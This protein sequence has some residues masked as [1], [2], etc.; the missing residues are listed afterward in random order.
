MVTYYK[1][2]VTVDLASV[3]FG[4]LHWA[5]KRGLLIHWLHACIRSAMLCTASIR[6]DSSTV[7]SSGSH[8]VHRSALFESV[9]RCKAT[10][11]MILLF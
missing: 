11:R 1:S 8:P 9:A 4:F 2:Q 10:L 7:D 3:W 5:V 6:W